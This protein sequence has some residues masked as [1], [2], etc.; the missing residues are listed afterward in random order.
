[1]TSTSRHIDREYEAELRR[2]RDQLLLMGA[3]VEALL[4]DTVNA[5]LRRDAAR[6]RMLFRTDDAIDQLEVEIDELCLRILARR[7]PVASDLRFITVTLKAVT[8]LERM[9][10]LAANMCTQGAALLQQSDVPFPA[11]VGRM[12]DAVQRMV[13]DALD[14][15][16]RGDAEEA[17]AV[18]HA[19]AEVDA[20]YATVF[21]HLLEDMQQEPT[22]IERAAKMQAI[23]KCLERI[24]DHATNLAELVVFLVKGKDIRHAP[25]P[26]VA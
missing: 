3:R 19:D 12:A 25:W 11:E 2:L 26:T 4:R 21:A 17:S 18:I 15:L 22:H 1:M 7:Q 24:A 14:A 23:S 8:D 5:L 10:D 16:V 6:L 9:G 20:C 13:H